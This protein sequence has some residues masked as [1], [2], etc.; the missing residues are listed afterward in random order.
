MYITLMKIVCLYENQV[1][2][3]VSLRLKS[4]N[5]MGYIKTNVKMFQFLLD[6]DLKMDKQIHLVIRS[7][8]YKLHLLVKTKLFYLLWT[9]RKS[10]MRLCYPGSITVT[11]SVMESTPGH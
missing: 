5:L 1:S 10:H 3:V 8:F 4:T 6:K 11:L 9:L 7:S 2:D